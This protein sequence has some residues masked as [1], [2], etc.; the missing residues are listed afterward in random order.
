MENNI[1]L[2]LT[3]PFAAPRNSGLESSNRQGSAVDQLL[4]PQAPSQ[5]ARTEEIPSTS[6]VQQVQNQPELRTNQTNN[7]E[8]D[9]EARQQQ[10]E[11]FLS[12]L[13]GQ[14]AENFRGIDVES[15]LEIQESF[16]DRPANE[17]QQ[18]ES[19][20]EAP[21]AFNSPDEVA[22]Q[23]QQNPDQQLQQRLQ[24]RLSDRIANDPGTEFPQLIQTAV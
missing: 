3:Q 16:R 14:D 11:S 23:D 20:A 9:P 1:S 21:A 7:A 15:A 19:F 18:T 4:A 12:E 22:A 8:Q 13:T 6:Q 5:V 24:D 10:I 17:P 2:G